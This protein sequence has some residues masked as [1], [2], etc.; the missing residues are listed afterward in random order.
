MFSSWSISNFF[1]ANGWWGGVAQEGPVAEGGW[2]LRLNGREDDGVLRAEYKV[3]TGRK[4]VTG[5]TG[6]YKTVGG[7]SNR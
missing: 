2:L 1:S 6:G 7:H 5:Q 4:A 3:V